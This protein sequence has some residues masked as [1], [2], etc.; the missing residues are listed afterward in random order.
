MAEITELQLSLKADGRRGLFNGVRFFEVL[1]CL[2]E[3]FV[4]VYELTVCSFYYA[5]VFVI[6]MTFEDWVR[7]LLWARGTDLIDSSA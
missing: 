5:K 2:V 1:A 3:V 7:L 6:W 4:E